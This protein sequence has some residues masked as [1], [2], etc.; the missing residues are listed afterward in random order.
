MA[1]ADS[2]PACAVVT[3]IAGCLGHVFSARIGGDDAARASSRHLALPA[4]I[5]RSAEALEIRIAGEH[6]SLGVRRAGLDA[7]PG[8]VPWL[9]RRVAFV[10][11]EVP[12]ESEPWA[13]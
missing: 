6:V 10:F 11:D 8:W 13:R 7:N 1:S 2:L 4:R 5:R 12:L 3:Q 9:R